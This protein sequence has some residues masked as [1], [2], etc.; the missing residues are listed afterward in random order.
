MAA[1]V[2][3]AST[4]AGVRAFSRQVKA[5]SAFTKPSG[6]QEQIL[7]RF[8]LKIRFVFGSTEKTIKRYKGERFVIKFILS[9]IVGI[10]LFF[11]PVFS[12]NVPLVALVDFLKRLL[13][14]ACINYLVLLF[15]LSLLVT[16]FLGKVIKIKA[17]AEY[18]KEDGL[19]KILFYLLAVIFTIMVI[20]NRGPAQILDP[21]IGGLALSLAGSVMLTVTLAGWFV[22]MILKSGIVEFMGIL[23]EP[24]M[25][26]CFTLPG[27][28]AVNG[29]AS[30]V[31][32]PAVGV[33]MTEQLYRERDYTERERDLLYLPVFPFAASASLAS[34]YLSAALNIFTLR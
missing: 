30:F 9:S 23:I 34:W 15:C 12:G 4:S 31:S 21:N 13:G 11:A 1:D 20:T 14:A 28:A 33:F 17:F 5:H 24:T 27:C 3:P 32:A 7:R 29:I 8:V 22:V 19:G 18:H 10:F 6:P 2:F 25:R 26:P 16:V